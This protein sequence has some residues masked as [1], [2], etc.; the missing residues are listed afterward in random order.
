MELFATL[1]AAF[2]GGLA[3]TS[4]IQLMARN[5]EWET[6]VERQGENKQVITKR[7]KNK[8]LKKSGN[9]LINGKTLDQIKREKS[10]DYPDDPAA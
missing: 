3:G 4:L 7:R 2:L 10:G 6:I 5:D 1:F 9:M 8:R